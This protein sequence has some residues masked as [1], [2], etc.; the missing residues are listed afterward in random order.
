VLSPYERRARLTPGLM[1]IAPISIA[2]ATLGL[3]RFAA[4]AILS[5]LLSAAGGTYVLAVLVGH[6]G[7]RAQRDL[8]HQWGGPPTLRFLRTRE[9][10]T[11]ATQRD[12]WRDAVATYTGTSLLTASEEAA[13]PQAADDAINAAIAQCLPLGHGGAEGK[14]LVVAENAQYG[15]ERNVYGFRWF[16][17]AGSL[18]SILGL[19]IALATEFP[20]SQGPVIAGLVLEALFLAFWMVV[21]SKGRT[22][23]AGERYATKLLD[24]VTTASKGR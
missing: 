24:A 14:T 23:E 6:S 20:I 9:R 19:I 16:G 3:E 15:F 8:W 12:I 10:A 17:Q 1:A 18:L 5:G 21:P 4:V 11:N 22:A 7:R 13:D 2:I